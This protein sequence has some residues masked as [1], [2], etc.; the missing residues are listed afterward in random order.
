MSNSRAQELA[1]TYLERNDPTGWFEALYAEASG[2]VGKIPWA[3]LAPNPNLVS[4]LNSFLPSY[5][6]KETLLIGC[7]LGDDA[8]ELARRGFDVTAFD[9]SP[10]AIRWARR[11]H[12][13]TKVGYQVADLFNLPEEWERAFTF[14]IESYTLQS[15]T[16]NLLEIGIE[17]VARTVEENGYLLVIARGREEQQII[18]GP[19]WPLTQN[20]IYYFRDL[21]L[22]MIQFDDLMDNETPSVRRFRAL[23]KRL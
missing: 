17:A 4:L 18:E 22:R 19:P 14:V 16:P 21:G 12:P 13:D 23:F 9:I 2:D 10:E 8:E 6:V 11:R 3:D 20:E 5:M 15:L 7:G 1:N